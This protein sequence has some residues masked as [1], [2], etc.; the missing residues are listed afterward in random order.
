MR[1]E[2][3]Y[4][5]TANTYW[6]IF[7]GRAVKSAEARAYQQRARL[8]ALT[9]GCRPL[10][11]PV[12][13]TVHVYRPRRRGDLDNVLKVLLD[14]LNGIAWRDDGQVVELH[15][16]RADDAARPRAVVTVEAA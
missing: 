2:L 11:G 10:D 5:P 16:S 4:P 3:P 8:M 9:A 14:S 15:A 1:L 12:V 7:R 13:V 6:R